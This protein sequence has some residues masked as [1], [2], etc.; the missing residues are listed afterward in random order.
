MVFYV[1][2]DASSNSAANAVTGLTIDGDKDVH[3][4]DDLF[5]PD[6]IIHEGDTIPQ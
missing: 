6:K 5:I 2:G 1:N 3:V 4:Y